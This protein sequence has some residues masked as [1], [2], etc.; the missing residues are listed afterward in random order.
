MAPGCAVA[1]A[2]S[3]A[4]TGI[5]SGNRLSAGD[6]DYHGDARAKLSLV[7]AANSIARTESSRVQFCQQFIGAAQMWDYNAA[8]HHKRD[9]KRLF[10][11]DPGHA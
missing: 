7:T 5:G 11:F 10:L 3:S 2:P 8:A 9:V 6:L 1:H 4:A